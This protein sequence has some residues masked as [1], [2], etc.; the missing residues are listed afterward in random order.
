MPEQLTFDLPARPA[1]GRDDFFVSAANAVA[2]ATV[3]DWQ[4]W[5][6]GK[7]ILVGPTGAGKTHLAHVWA[8]GTAALVIPA[9]DL[10]ADM[11]AALV[12]QNRHIAVE[13]VAATAGQPDGDRALL[14]LHNLLLAEGGRLLLTASSAPR[15][16]PLGLP[17]LSSRMLATSVALLA[18]PDDA[19]LAAVLVKQ[20]ADRQLTVSPAV[21]AWLVTRMERSFE[22]AQ[23]L[24]AALDRA[25][26][27]ERRAI[28]RPFAA[29]VLDNL[30]PDTA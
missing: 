15:Q 28:T 18:P 13:D 2:L 8:A 1:L 7:L 3:E 14:H 16:W 26:L 10:N 23:R 25:A 17:D 22:G 19:L 24:V 9:Q 11:V 6:A 30:S 29:R 4:N 21:I 27:S 5:P 12:A 20:F